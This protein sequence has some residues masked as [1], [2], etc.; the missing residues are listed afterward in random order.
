MNAITATTAA[1]QA[2]SAGTASQNNSTNGS[3]ISSDFET[4]LK[5]LTAQLENQDPLNPLESQEFA[6]QLAKIKKR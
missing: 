3:V 4:F 6:G 1:T 5:M 2:A